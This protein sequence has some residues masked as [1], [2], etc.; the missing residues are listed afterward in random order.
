MDIQQTEKESTETSVAGLSM[1][2]STLVNLPEHLQQGL[3]SI[4]RS[5]FPIYDCHHIADHPTSV[6]KFSIVW[7][8][9]QKLTR[10]K[11]QFILGPMV[12]PSTGTMT[13]AICHIFGMKFYL[14]CKTLN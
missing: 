11:N 8:E 6:V 5:P 12:H 7:R 13:N 1:M 2:K 3:M 4:S 9:D 10:S 14:T